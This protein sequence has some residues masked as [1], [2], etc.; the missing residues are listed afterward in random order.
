MWIPLHAVFSHLCPSPS[1]V[2]NVCSSGST[3]FSLCFIN[4]WERPQLPCV[5]GSLCPH[6]DSV[7][8]SI[9]TQCKQLNEH[10]R[11]RTSMHDCQLHRKLRMHASINM[12]LSHM[13]A[14]TCTHTLT[15]QSSG[16][17]NSQLRHGSAGKHFI[18]ITLL[19]S[20]PLSHTHTLYFC[21]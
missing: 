8:I 18:L 11:A 5:G 2:Y 17:K 10:A 4:I 13:C 21:I 12:L 9:S 19:F 7:D 16:G 20:L 6:R 1:S 15:C 14:H 3:W